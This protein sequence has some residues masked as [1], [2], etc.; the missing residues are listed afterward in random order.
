M[1]L[2]PDTRL[3]EK[4]E[5]VRYR[6]PRIKKQSKY[7]GRQ[8][9][10]R[11]TKRRI[12]GPDLEPVNGKNVVIAIPSRKIVACFST[13]LSYNAPLLFLRYHYAREWNNNMEEESSTEYIKRLNKISISLRK[14]EGVGIEEM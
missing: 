13:T 11:A 9:N 7:E 4:Y 2:P 8:D 1:L 3:G 6:C 14:L 10:K 12:N 5:L